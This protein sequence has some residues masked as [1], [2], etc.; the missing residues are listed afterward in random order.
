MVS[1]RLAQKKIF[2]EKKMR[3]LI[4]LLV[5]FNVYAQEEGPTSPTVVDKRRE[6]TEK[7][8]T[9]RFS[10]QAYRPNYLLPVT[11][12]TN[13]NQNIIKQFGEVDDELNGESF[14]YIEAKFQLSFRFSIAR[15]VIFDNDLLWIGYTQ[16]SMWQVYNGDAS[17]P[18]RETNYEPEVVW[19]VPLDWNIFGMKLDYL[20]VSL[21]HQSNGQY[22]FLSRSWNRLIGMGVLSRG[23][24]AAN[25][26]VWHRFYEAPDS[27]D[28]PQITK[29]MGNFDLT[30]A[31]KFSSDY[32]LSLV[33][34]NNLRRQSEN[35]GMLELNF[36][37][38]TGSSIKGYAQVVSG[39]GETLI[40]YDRYLTRV[41]IGIVL[42]DWL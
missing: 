27:D 9:N 40:D 35:K 16:L 17:A 34:R 6:E 11:Y 4:P 42:I 5:I 38:P 3:F 30:L 41:G 21:N 24:F 7:S 37:F 2:S 23:N 13:P 18:F 29:Y 22:N 19:T 31:Y 39:Y 32:L 33:I 15:G 26:R 36:N 1:A 14:D 20:G 10:L 25:F 8:E 12:N 28:N